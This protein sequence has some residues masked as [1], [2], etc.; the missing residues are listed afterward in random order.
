[1]ITEGDKR[2]RNTCRSDNNTLNAKPVWAHKENVLY[3]WYHFIHFEILFYIMFFSDAGTYYTQKERTECTEYQ[4]GS[5]SLPLDMFAR[6]HGERKNGGIFLLELIISKFITTSHSSI[7]KN[8]QGASITI[9]T[10]LISRDSWL[11]AFPK[12][13]VKGKEEK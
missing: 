10:S 12:K 1:M 11:F 4:K 3:M 13:K 9:S 7:D 5:L 8:A 2:G 6:L